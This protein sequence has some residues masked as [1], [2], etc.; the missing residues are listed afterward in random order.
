MNKRKLIEEEEENEM[1]L[2]FWI[3]TLNN[4]T[5]MTANINCSRYVTNIMLPIVLIATITHF[6]TYWLSS[7]YENFYFFFVQLDQIKYKFNNNK[8]KKCWS[9]SLCSSSYF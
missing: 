8:K 2:F 7:K 4:C 1:A 6:T 5:P 9:C 3:I